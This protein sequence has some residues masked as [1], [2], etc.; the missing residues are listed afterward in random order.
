MSKSKWGSILVFGDLYSMRP[1]TCQVRHRT[2]LRT[3]ATFE[4]LRNRS[5]QGGSAG[6]FP[7]NLCHGLGFG[8]GHE[9]GGDGQDELM[10]V[11]VFSL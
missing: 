9:E 7:C 11:W 4:S 1:L 10:D 5:R 6:T 8:I 3:Q 2:P